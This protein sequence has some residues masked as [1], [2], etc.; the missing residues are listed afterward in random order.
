[1]KPLIL[2]ILISVFSGAK[3]V[4][5]S[6]IVGSHQS[7]PDS[8]WKGGMYLG[9]GGQNIDLED[10]NRALVQAGVPKLTTGLVGISFGFTNRHRDQ[11]SYGTIQLSYFTT[12]DD[13]N[14]AGNDARLDLWKLPITG[15][16]D[17]IPSEKWLIAPYLQFSPNLARLKVSSIT[18]ITTFQG[19]LNNLNSPDELIKRYS[20]GIFISGGIGLGIERRYTFP[21]TIN[22]IGIRAGYEISPRLGWQTDGANYFLDNSPSYR[23]NGLVVEFI[24]RVEPNPSTLMDSEMKPRGLFKYFN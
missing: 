15:H 24:L 3:N 17:L 5:Q 11:D 23:S 13:G 8:V 6:P 7:I 20:T 16:Y 14:D 21:G 19:S 18:D 4:A 1:M 9:I 22:H 10:L 2:L 12:F